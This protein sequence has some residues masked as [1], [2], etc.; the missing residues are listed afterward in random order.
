MTNPSSSAVQRRNHVTVV[1]DG[2]VTL[3]LAHG[4]GC[5]QNV[6]RL[7][8]ER[9]A[10]DYRLVLLDYVGGGRSDRAAYDPARY[11]AL[12]GYAR[13]LAEV[14]RAFGGARP[15]L[16][17]HSISGTLGVMAS[18]EAPDLFS[19]MVLLGPSPRYLDEPPSYRGGFCRT[20]VDDF[21]TLMD[22]NFMGWATAFSNIVSPDADVARQMF[23]SFC[24]TD[25]RTMRPFAEL[26]FLSDVR[27]LLS[28]VSVPTMIVQCA[29]DAIVPVAVGEAMHRAVPGST[30][31]LAAVAGH[32]PHLSAPDL[33]ASLVREFAPPGAPS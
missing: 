12:D 32:C 28:R 8:V 13:D 1:G 20:D 2:P 6:W 31:R 10:G 26:T 24:S 29:D 16:V 15:V 22:Q 7:V 4:L 9:L 23:E 33:V 19:R 11:G 21:L 18:A 14:T 25:P 17:G 30:Y 5:D 3:V 27:A